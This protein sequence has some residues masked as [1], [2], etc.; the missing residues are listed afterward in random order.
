M[1]KLT[2][3]VLIKI[4]LLS[5]LWGNIPANAA[6]VVFGSE[7]T[8]EN[9]IDVNTLMQKPEHYL[10]R[11]FTIKGVISKVCKKRGCWMELV[12]E[13]TDQ[14]LIVKVKDGEMVFPMSKLG[15]VALATGTLSIV[16]LDLE[17]SR[18]YLAHR[19]EEQGQN[20][21][22]ESVTEALQLYRFSPVSVTILDQ[23]A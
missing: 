13:P 20:F 17:Q 10:N 21:N 16:K 5:L 19:A 3:K 18:N 23:K 7:V 12:T 1:D 4:I 2:H 15:H 9:L 8:D 6:P 22:P 14:P 11:E